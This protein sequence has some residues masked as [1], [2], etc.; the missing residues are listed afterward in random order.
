[1]WLQRLR[2]LDK[3]I[4]VGVIGAGSMG[5]GLVY[6]CAITPGI[7]CAVLADLDIDRAIASVEHTGLPYKVVRS[8]SDVNDAI[9]LGV[10][11][12]CEDGA[13]V[14]ECDG[15]DALIES[16]SAIS[17]GGRFAE[18]ALLTGKHLV[19]MNSEIDLSF[20]PHF[21]RLAREN[22][23]VFTSCDGDQ[24]GVIKRLHDEMTLWGLE[25]VMAGNIKGFLDRYSNP[26]RIVPEADKRNLDYRMATAYTDGSK[27]AIE[28]ALVSNAL[29]YVPA[30][31]GMMGPRAGHV[32]DVFDLFDFHAIRETGRPVVDYILGA[33]PGGGVFCVGYCDDP[34]QMG[35]LSYYKMGSGPFY[36]FYRP[37][38]LCHVEAMQC[39]AEACL[40]G[41]SLLEPDYGFRANVNAFAKRD[42]H[43]GDVLD[44]LGGYDCYGL[45]EEVTEESVQ[46]V[47]P[48]CISEGARLLHDVAKDGRITMDD[49]AFENGNVALA[50]Y[51]KALGQRV[52]RTIA[53]EDPLRFQSV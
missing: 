15:I 26:T 50:M 29:D 5:R 39:V 11:A 4:T 47:L 45:I 6:Q 40:D 9:R 18:R 34:Y 38:H 42:L 31:P 7:R 3:E 33:E 13:L 16:T 35:M 8:L 10:M 51:E 49:V 2:S 48:L 21:L 37:Y 12:V 53:Q 14:S 36:L 30:R 27:L 46:T 17:E 32:S 41:T 24:H 44:G 1:M 23:L 19:L 20:G 22:G 43:A 52:S 28:M 25:P